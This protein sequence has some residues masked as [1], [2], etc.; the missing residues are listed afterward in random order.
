MTC[1]IV[2]YSATENTVKIVNALSKGIRGDIVFTRVDMTSYKKIVPSKA[3]LI[4]F[5]SPVYGGRI[6]SRIMK[7]FEMK[8]TKGKQIVGIAVYGNMNYGLSLKQYRKL[9][10]K[11]NC[12]L[13]GAGAFIGEH[14]YSLEEAPVASGRP[15]EKDLQ[16]AK[17]FGLAI[18]DKINKGINE[19]VSIPNTI[20]PLFI[21]KFPECM[22]KSW[23]KK[24]VI[25]GECNRCGLCAR[26]C[27][28][29]AIDSNTLMIDNNKCIRCF[30]CV[31]KCNIRARKAELIIKGLKY[32]FSWFGR[33]SRNNIWYI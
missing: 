14:T 22:V 6:L 12:S 13:I 29:K 24:P 32:P 20:L 17:L 28:T 9:A 15:N 25:Q 16:Q 31:K 8:C 27:P 19:E 33:K 7:C 1:E 10:R 3:G 23:V 18:Q 4:I 30:S 26:S 11:Q 2:Y 5:A 21:E